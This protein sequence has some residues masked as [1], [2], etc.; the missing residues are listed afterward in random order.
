M[1][2]ARLVKWSCIAR[3]DTVSREVNQSS[4]T[5]TTQTLSALETRVWRRKTLQPRAGGRGTCSQ[6]SQAGAVFAGHRL[7]S[8]SVC[9]CQWQAIVS[10]FA[11]GSDAWTTVRTQNRGGCT[12][13][14]A[15]L[16]RH[17]PSICRRGSAAGSDWPPA[18]RNYPLAVG[19]LYALQGELSRASDR[20]S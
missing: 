9:F 2:H 16:C 15:A 20:V 3:S 7:R 1:R 4:K 11:A 18:Q 10:G 8:V 17:P 12:K 13:R 19:S 14:E 5:R 6:V